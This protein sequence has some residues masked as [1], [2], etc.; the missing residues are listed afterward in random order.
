M[1]LLKTAVGC[2][3][4]HPKSEKLDRIFSVLSELLIFAAYTSDDIC[5]GG[6]LTRIEK[7]KK[8]LRSAEKVVP[9][10]HLTELLKGDKQDIPLNPS[11]RNLSFLRQRQASLFAIWIMLI[12]MMANHVSLLHWGKQQRFVNKL[13]QCTDVWCLCNIKPVCFSLLVPFFSTCQSM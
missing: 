6:V 13:S 10:T 11:R 4:Q 5:C 2:I 1:G 8:H 7:K 12:R 3:K 9:A